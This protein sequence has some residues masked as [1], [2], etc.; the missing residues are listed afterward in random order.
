MSR[1]P[2]LVSMRPG[3]SKE[4]E[5]TDLTKDGDYVPFDPFGKG[6]RKKRYEVTLVRHTRGE[7]KPHTARMEIRSYSP[8]Q[9][10]ETKHW[11]RNVI[12]GQTVTV[13]QRLFRDNVIT[14]YHEKR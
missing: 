8:R 9:L 2:V 4:A 3:K 1:T 12:E 7:V 6:V 13:R 5:T 11:T 14:I 10:R